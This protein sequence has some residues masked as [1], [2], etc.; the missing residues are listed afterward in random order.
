MTT[1]LRNRIRVFRGPSAVVGAIGPNVLAL[2]CFD[3]VHVGQALSSPSDRLRLL[4]EAGMD[5][6][7]L[8][9]GDPGALGV[10]EEVLTKRI[11]LGVMQAQLVVV[12]GPEPSAG[13][14]STRTGLVVE[15]AQ[16]PERTSPRPEQVLNAK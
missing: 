15:Q 1:S 13:S 8:F 12:R 6:V 5:F 3:G 7:V 10:P 14:A 16:V 2:D 9:P 11:L 4:Q